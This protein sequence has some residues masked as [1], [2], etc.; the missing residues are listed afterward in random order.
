MSDFD[1]ERG[2]EDDAYQEL[3]Q[4]AAR[5]GTRET[6]QGAGQEMFLGES[7]T[8]ENFVP[9][10]PEGYELP[11]D[12][13]N[14]DVPE[15]ISRQVVALLEGDREDIKRFCHTVG[16]TEDQA[17]K[18]F[19]A[20]GI[21]MAEHLAKGAMADT[22][23]V[24]ATLAKLAPDNADEFW[25][26]AKRGAAYLGIGKEIDAAGLTANPLVLRLVNAVGKLTGENKMRGAARTPRS[27]PVGE[28]AR[29]ELYKIVGSDAYKKNDPATM[30]LAERLAARVKR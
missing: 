15:E 27:L 12:W 2:V 10:S 6:G 16:M 4:E 26:T 1:G 23:N 14:E 21:I 9:D 22:E 19:D 18:A 5:E 30:Q 7:G 29:R 13:A 24:N 20:L 11:E 25:N 3:G 28:E 8:P 17:A